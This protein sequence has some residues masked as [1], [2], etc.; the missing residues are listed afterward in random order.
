MQN[1][2]FYGL[3]SENKNNKCVNKY[4]KSAKYSIFL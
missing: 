1:Y 3:K 4:L 2:I